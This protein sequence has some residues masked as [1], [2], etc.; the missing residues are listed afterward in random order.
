MELE[1]ATPQNAPI[2]IS[3][4]VTLDELISQVY[5]IRKKASEAQSQANE[6]K[7]TQKS[8]EALIIS[9]MDDQGVLVSGNRVAKVAIS[10]DVVPSVD[11]W[12][13]VFEYVKKKDAFYLLY[14]QISASS[15]RE[16]QNAGEAIPG[17]APFTRRKLSIR[18]A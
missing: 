18:K 8:L 4:G 6:L 11:D 13:K 16:L 17:T 7:E 1:L 12:E 5:E 2:E 14:K 15:Y 9:R 10:E 3:E